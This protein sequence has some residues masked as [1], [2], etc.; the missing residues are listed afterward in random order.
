MNI[1]I[2]QT[3]EPLHIDEGNVRPMRAMNLSDALADAGHHVL[4]WSSAF[5][6]Q[7]KRHRNHE[8]KRIRV[9]RQLEIRLIPS[10]G[11]RRHIGIGRLV[12]HAQLAFN[13]RKEIKQVAELP[14]VAFVG[15]PPI[16]TAAVLT[17]WLKKRGVP[18][19]LDIKDLW[20]SLFLEPIPKTIR[21]LGH[22][23]LWP[24]FHLAKRAMR[25]A[26]GISTM[27]R[28]Y[29]EW[30]LSYAGREQKESD[31]IFPLTS[32]KSKISVEELV[33]A[34]KWWDEQGVLDDGRPRIYF[35]G[36]FMSVFDWQPVRDAA[37]KAN[38]ASDPWEFII[39]GDGGAASKLRAMMSG[40]P[41]VRFP[42]WVDRPKIEVLAERCRAALAPYVNIENFTRNLPNKIVDALSLGLPILSP[43]QGEIAKLIEDHKVGLR[44]GTDAGR[45]LYECL[46]ILLRDDKQQ[47]EMSKNARALYDKEF[48]FEK[49]YG[50]LVKHL[51]NMAVINGC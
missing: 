37:I 15:F 5:Y 21:P 29:L 44:Y 4:L 11:Y 9:S 22:I 13:L 24:Y 40:L 51:E 48:S 2:L 34:R 7:K 10:R 49:V 17:R 31:G 23:V 39:C 33:E 3:G 47:K 19:L 43:L 38:N 18:V 30:A 27:A 35:V 46:Q 50:S 32:P 28:G 6:H 26:S 8:A 20:P 41:N 45:N 1:W 42:G 14:N 25:D 16:E 12:D 36:S